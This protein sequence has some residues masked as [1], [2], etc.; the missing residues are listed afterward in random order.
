MGISRGNI[1]TNI[2]K[3]GLVFN[4]DAANRACYPKT[5]TTAIDTIGNVSG[6]ISAATFIDN[7]INAFDFDAIDDEIDFGN[8][9]NFGNASTDSPFSISSWWKMDNYVSFRAINKVGLSNSEYRINT[10]NSGLLKFTLYDNTNSN[11]IGFISDSDFSSYQDNWINVVCTYDGSSTAGGCIAYVNGSV[12]ATSTNT[13]GSY[14]AMHNLGQSFK[15]GK[16]AFSSVGSGTNGQIANTQIY[17]R[18]LSST[19]VLHNYNALKG[20]FE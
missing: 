16:S 12:I 14:T 8:N 15:I 5:G 19:E 10:L 7:N 2:I 6:T 1:T 18:A 13:A 9:F 4:L 20:R 3:S 11:Y 17:N